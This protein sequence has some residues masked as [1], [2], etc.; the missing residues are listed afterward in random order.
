M[1]IRSRLPQALLVGSLVTLGLPVMSFAESLP[2]ALAE[3]YASNPSL[4]A[5]RAQLRA[6]DEEYVQAEVGYRPTV[7]ATE[8]Y[9]YSYVDTPPTTATTTNGTAGGLTVTQPLYT[10]GRVA[11]QLDAAQA[12]IF[13]GRAALR[14]TETD[15][16]LSV[17]QAYL[18]VRRERETLEIRDS[19]IQVLGHQVEQANAS[20]TAGD[21][22]RTDIAQ[23]EARLAQAR[24]DR[25]ATEADLQAAVSAYTA[26]VGHAPG[27][28]APEPS[29]AALLPPTPDAAFDLAETN[30]AALAQARFA[31]QAA[32]ARVAEAKAAN[33][34]T[35][36]VSGSFGYTSGAVVVDGQ[37]LNPGATG[38]LFSNVAP[39]AT[40]MVTASIPVFTGGLNSSQIRQTAELAEAAR[41]GVEGVRRQVTQAVAT[42]W[43]RLLGERERID[44]VQQQVKADELA[45]EGVG[46][47]KKAGY[48]TELDV[49][50]AEQ[51]LAASRLTLVSAEH[52]EYLTTATLLTVIGT[53]TVKSLVP[54]EAAYDPASHYRKVTH[55]PGWVPWSPAVGALDR[56]GAP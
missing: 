18:D 13:A 27:D 12:D 25:A 6:T 39:N 2:D 36:G 1:P 52:D 29:L 8:S 26:V 50:N 32:A 44:A 33:R 51:E 16:L 43:E 28:L 22:T 31:E 14:R 35:V 41:V 7:S 48:R 11:R 54:T 9:T 34:P 15:V 38:G 4:Q 23:A 21:G 46:E 49:L 56:L 20:F 5:Q 42:G 40:V 55:A 53:L 10:G 47:E 24:S 17:I 19:V 45:F 37:L 30:N 3:A